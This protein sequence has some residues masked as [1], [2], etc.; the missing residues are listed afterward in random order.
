MPPPPYVQPT[1]PTPRQFPRLP[2]DG[3]QPD[4]ALPQYPASL[5]GCPG[6]GRCLCSRRLLFLLLASAADRQQVRAARGEGRGGG[7]L[8]ERRCCMIGDEQRGLTGGQRVGRLQTAGGRPARERYNDASHG[9]CNSRGVIFR[10]RSEGVSEVT[11]GRS[12]QENALQ[13]FHYALR[14]EKKKNTKSSIQAGKNQQ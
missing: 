3:P 13:V 10:R 12:S 2:A 7:T 5:P 9:A 1:T 11:L 6:G 4:P 14:C 8:G